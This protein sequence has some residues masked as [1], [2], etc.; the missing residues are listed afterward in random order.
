MVASGDALPV[1]RARDVSIH[2]RSNTA[3]PEYVAVRGVTLDIG[4]GEVVGLVGEAGA[5]KS[6]LGLAMAGLAYRTHPGLGVPEICGGTLEVL[7]RRMRRLGHRGRDKITLR[8]G[9]LPQDGAERLDSTFTI[10]ES[11]AEPIY[12]RDRKFN[13]REA[14]DAVAYLV[15]AVRLPLSVMNRM[16]WELSSGQRQRVALARALILEPVLLIADEPTRGVDVSVRQG[17][18]D[19][20]RDLQ[21]DRAFSALIISSDLSVATSISDR[22]AVMQHGIL[23]GLGTPAEVLERPEH[24]YVKDLSRTRPT[25]IHPEPIDRTLDLE[26]T[27]P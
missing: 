12:R 15:D 19:A 20:L 7:G 4:L 5:G 25:M 23:V 18:L 16:P 26:G 10:A 1:V 13:T 24:E 17:V 14:A 21:Q 22:L 3:S 27:T 2:Y 11:I 9:H 8:V 6:T